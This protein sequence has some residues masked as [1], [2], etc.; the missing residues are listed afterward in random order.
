M[1]GRGIPRWVLVILAL[2]GWLV[3]V[4]LAMASCHGPSRGLASLRMD[5]RLPRDLELG[6]IPIAAGTALLIWIFASGLCACPELPE[7]LQRLG[8]PFLMTAGP[9]AYTRNPGYV[10]ELAPLARRSSS[11]ASSLWSGWWS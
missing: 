11:A 8:P 2:F 1:R 9:Y 6:L 7:R 4:P 10:A 5:G 3:G